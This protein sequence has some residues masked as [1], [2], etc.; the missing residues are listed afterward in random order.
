MVRSKMVPG[1]D[2][3]VPG[4]IGMKVPGMIGMKVDGMNDKEVRDVK[5]V[6][7][8]EHK[9]RNDDDL[10]QTQSQIIIMPKNIIIITNKNT[11]SFEN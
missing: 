1:M 4:M 11:F 3:M 8:T 5:N 2:M 6:D 9:G 10:P 7:R